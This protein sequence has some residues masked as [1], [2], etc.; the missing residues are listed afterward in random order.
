MLVK[1]SVSYLTEIRSAI[2]KSEWQPVV[3]KRTGANKRTSTF[4]AFCYERDL[5]NQK[6]N[7]FY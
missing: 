7:N 2:L 5:N 4:A 3:L 6:I 1:F